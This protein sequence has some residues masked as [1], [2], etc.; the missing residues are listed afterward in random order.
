MAYEI[1]AQNN[2]TT[3]LSDGVNVIRVPARVT[4]ATSTSYTITKV[5]NNTATLEDE[6]GKVLKDIP[7]VAVLYGGGSGS[8]LPDQT[9]Q[10][11]KFLTTDGTDASWADIKKV[12]T[13]VTLAVADW[14]DDSQTVSVTGITADGVVLVSP[15]PTD[16]SAYTTAGILC[17]AQAAGTLTFICSTTPSADIDVNVVML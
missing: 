13:T 16:Q 10:S 3:T 7:C 5:N 4:L 6:N 17:T 2:T 14:S 15:I 9:G 8:A 1:I 11:G 12:N